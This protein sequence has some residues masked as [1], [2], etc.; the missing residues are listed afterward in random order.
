MGLPFPDPE[1]RQ[2]DLSQGG[3]RSRAKSKTGS[4]IV[5]PGSDIYI[6]SRCRL[7]HALEDLHMQSIHYGAKEQYLQNFPQHLLRDFGRKC[8]GVLLRGSHD[9]LA[10]D[11]GGCARER[12][13]VVATFSI[14]SILFG[15]PW[16]DAVFLGILSCGVRAGG[17]APWQ[18][19]RMIGFRGSRCRR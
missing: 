13:A 18:Y 10:R 3:I 8:L 5:I 11:L 4:C 15:M 12:H 19:A 1:G 14:F 17:H 16:P 7:A 6:G 2:V 9:Y